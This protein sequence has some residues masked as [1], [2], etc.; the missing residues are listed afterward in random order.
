ML[1][2]FHKGQ[3]FRP[4]LFLFAS[5]AAFASASAQELRTVTSPDGQIEFHAFVT[6]PS[7]ALEDQL[8]YQVS[9][10]GKPLLGPSLLGFDIRN[11]NLL[12]EKP[13]VTGEKADSGDHYRSLL[14][15]YLQNGTQGRRLN[16]EIRVYNDGV[17]FRYVI[18]KSTMLEELMI[19]EEETEFHFAADAHAVPALLS[20]F[21]AAPAAA[22]P[23]KLSE[24]PEDSLIALPLVAEAPGVGWISIGEGRRQGYPPMFLNH[25]EGTTLVSALPP[26]ANDPHLAVDTTTPFTCP[27]RVLRIGPTRESVTSAPSD[28]QAP[29]W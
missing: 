23:M 20:D 3:A 24:I 4:V 13:G 22:R 26:L 27:W 2:G 5:L 12:G 18:P 7:P 16:L 29:L 14:L 17:A 21:K 28:L 15:E 19:E 25:E 9:Y 6:R 10:R 8:A 11:Q 1:W